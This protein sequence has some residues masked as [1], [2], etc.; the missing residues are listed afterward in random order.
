MHI[1]TNERSTA[2][3]KRKQGNNGELVGRAM[4]DINCLR[5]GKIACNARKDI[6]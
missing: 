1:T 2:C 3:S 6:N 5:A 4:I